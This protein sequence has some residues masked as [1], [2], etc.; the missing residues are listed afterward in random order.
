W[1]MFC[2]AVAM[3]STSPMIAP[4]AFKV[5]VRKIGRIG[6]TISVEMSENRLDSASRNEFRDRPAKYPSLIF[7]MTNSPG[8]ARNARSACCATRSEAEVRH[9]VQP[10]ASA[11]AGLAA[12]SIAER[13]AILAGI[14]PARERPVL[15]I[16]RDRLP[17]AE[18]RND[19]GGLVPELL[20]PIDHL[21]RHAVFE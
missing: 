14:G 18:R 12:A 19:L 5:C 2:V 4:S 20:Q 15:P 17:A 21:C 10:G 16:D 9:L 7:A 1:T 13:A 3:P 6:S 8:P 11:V